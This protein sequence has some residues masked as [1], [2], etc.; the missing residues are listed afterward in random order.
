MNYDLDINFANIRQAKVLRLEALRE[1]AI[2]SFRNRY[3]EDAENIALGFALKLSISGSN[4]DRMVPMEILGHSVSSESFTS[5]V[6]PQR[7][8]DVPEDSLTVS[9]FC[10]ALAD[11]ISEYLL[12]HPEKVRTTVQGV[13][14]KLSFPHNYYI[15]NLTIDEKNACIAWLKNHDKIMEGVTSGKWRPLSLKAVAYF[16][17]QNN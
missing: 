13:P 10:A 8:Q 12:R 17:A 15:H 9:R 16:A 7:G 6:K 3:A 1:K 14:P 11:D 4:L 2:E 5:C